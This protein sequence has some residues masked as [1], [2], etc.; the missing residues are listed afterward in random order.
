MKL[1]LLAA[2][3]ITVLSACNQKSA[4]KEMSVHGRWNTSF[5]NG[6]KVLAVFRKDGTHDYFIN[7][8]LF[9]SGKF[10][11]QNNELSEADPICNGDY[12]ATYTVNFTSA[13]EM[14]FTV[15]QDTCKPRVYDLNGIKMKREP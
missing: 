9:S 5:K 14:Q 2:L 8:K 4:N 7:G 15:V 12:Y 11:F 1:L 13:D 10:T 6:D 3:A